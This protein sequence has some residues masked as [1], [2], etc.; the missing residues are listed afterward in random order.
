MTKRLPCP[1]APGPLEAYAVGFDDLFGTLAQRRG[2]REYLAGLLLP[3]DRNKT[4]TC[5]AGTEPVVGAQHAAV[6]RLQFFLSESTWDGEQVNARRLELMLAD[7]ATA[8]HDGGV[9]VI[10]DSGDRKD[11]SATAHV[12]KQYLGSVGK[13]DRGVVTVTTCW[14]DERLYYPLHA[15]PYTPAHH[16]PGGK[17][18]PAFRTKLRI[19]AALARTAKTAGVVF[20]AVVADCAY[21]DHNTFRA[22]LSDARMPFVMALKRGHGTW[23]YKDAFRPVDAARE[24]AWHGPEQSGDWQP[25]TRTF[26]NGHTA[27]WWA[28]DARLGWWG[29]DG[30]IRLVVA[31][32]DPATLPE[33]STWYLAT[34][35]P[36]PGSPRE[37]HSGHRAADLT[38]VVRLYGLRHWVEQ[39]YKQ[40]KDELGWADFQV[41]SDTAIR[42]HQTLVNCAFSFCWS[43][44][45]APDPP[46]RPGRPCTRS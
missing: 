24:L 11:G 36:R 28:A 2:F 45:F 46:A 31:T 21:G 44:W 15:V 34:N 17:S 25:V 27:T 20:R 19:G 37:A 10:D 39:S 12:G 8:P 14:A 7:S 30:V 5:L 35:L 38:E 42:R 32:T 16:F 23:Q 9:L 29:P 1:P 26:R 18:D 40:V 4:L 43:T 41:R 13:I 33:T 6:Q 3:R 22:A